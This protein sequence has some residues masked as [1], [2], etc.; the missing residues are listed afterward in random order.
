M[1][2]LIIVPLFLVAL[3]VGIIAGM[4]YMSGDRAQAIKTTEGGLALVAETMKYV[5]IGIV[6]TEILFAVLLIAFFTWRT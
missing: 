1:I 3:I 2:R 6:A 5:L 4:Q